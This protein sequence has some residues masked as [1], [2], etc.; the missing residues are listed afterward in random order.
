MWAWGWNATGQLGDG[1]TVDR[2]E[3]VR[4]RYT[5][6]AGIAAGPLHSLAVYRD[7]TV[8]AWGWNGLGQL[9]DGTTTDRLEP[10]PG[11]A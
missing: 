10:V 7:G 4:V 9:G 6:V 2:H 5:G 11:R 1:T 3:P 8:M